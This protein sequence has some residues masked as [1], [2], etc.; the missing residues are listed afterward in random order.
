MAKKILIPQTINPDTIIHEIRNAIRR[1]GKI[2]KPY[3]SAGDDL[4][5][6]VALSIT[7]SE[8]LYCTINNSLSPAV[9]EAVK[10]VIISATHPKYP[11]IIAISIT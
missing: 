9:K 5:S 3:D 10:K 4:H 11:Q 7:N 6:Q 2:L 8:S 1:L